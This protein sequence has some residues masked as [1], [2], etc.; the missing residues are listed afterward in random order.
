MPALGPIK[1]RELI[2]RLKQL[3]FTGPHTGGKHEYMV[4]GKIRLAL[5]NPHQGDVSRDLLIRILRQ[6]DIDRKAWEKL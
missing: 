4:K 1:R 6:G 2:R 5:P 3:G